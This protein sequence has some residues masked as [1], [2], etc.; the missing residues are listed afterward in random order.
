MAPLDSLV[1]DA[2]ARQLCDMP[3]ARSVDDY[4]RLGSRDLWDDLQ[5]VRAQARHLI[6]DV[7]GYEAD[8]RRLWKAIIT[9]RMLGLWG[10]ETHLPENIVLMIC[11]Y[12]FIRKIEVPLPIVLST[13]RRRLS[14]A[15]MPTLRWYIRHDMVNMYLAYDYL[16]VMCERARRRQA[17][18][19]AALPPHLLVLDTVLLLVDLIDR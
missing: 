4:R 5:V 12:G 7:V 19:A 16:L 10:A 18:A 11:A 3:R 17:E 6:A 15:T 14:Y 9:A 8:R 2:E 13:P 1:C